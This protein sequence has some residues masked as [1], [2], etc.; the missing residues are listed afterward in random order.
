[1]YVPQIIAV[2]H[3][4]DAMKNELEL[5]TNWELPYE[6]LLTRRSAAI[7]FLTPAA[8]SE[9]W[10]QKTWSHLKK[11][12]HF[13]QRVNHEKTLSQM[14]YRVTFNVEEKQ[15]NELMLAENDKSKMVLQ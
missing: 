7:F 2:K 13:S 15:K 3:Q 12:E 9:E 5:I 14:S 1:M 11:F 4:L 8:E 6:D 10:L